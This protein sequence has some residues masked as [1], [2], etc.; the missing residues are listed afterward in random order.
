M[1]IMHLTSIRKTQVQSLARSQFFLYSCM[2]YNLLYSPACKLHVGLV[3]YD[4][5]YMYNNI[6]TVCGK[7]CIITCTGKT[8]YHKLLVQ[9]IRSY[10]PQAV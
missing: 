2:H 3:S 4:V 1:H 5:V 6:N 10:K 9:D 8:S 7:Q